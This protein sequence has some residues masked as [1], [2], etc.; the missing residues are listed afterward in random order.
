MDMYILLYFRWIANKDIQYSTGS[1]AQCY[2]AAWMG[3]EFE[4][5]W[6]HIYV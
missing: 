4:G 1:C 5:T 6:M 2:M 3:E